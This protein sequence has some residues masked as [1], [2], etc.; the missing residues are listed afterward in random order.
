MLDFEEDAENEEF[1]ASNDTQDDAEE[2]TQELSQDTA[3]NPEKADAKRI[4]QSRIDKLTRKFREEER[5][6]QAWEARYYAEQE[7]HRKTQAELLQLTQ[8]LIRYRTDNA[9]AED[10]FTDPQVKALRQELEAIKSQTTSREQ[11]EK[12]AREEQER[13]K[14]MQQM[15]ELKQKFDDFDDVMEEAQYI[16]VPQ[17]SGLQVL[18][19]IKPL[20]PEQ[21]YFLAKNPVEARRIA[22]L[23]D[24]YEAA[25]AIKEL[26]KGEKKRVAVSKAPPPPEKVSGGGSSGKGGIDYS[27]MS[28]REIL[29]L[30]NN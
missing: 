5:K 28:V 6:S 30:R 9:Y 2:Q 17:N 26:Q 18:S 4:A 23:N 22:K 12:A 7:A 27:K 13:I 11:A 14:A 3:N 24:P 25:A 19:K 20:T 21:I 1:I 16:Q 8:E 10:D 15:E 29:A